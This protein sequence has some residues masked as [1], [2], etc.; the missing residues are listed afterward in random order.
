MKNKKLN[1][2]IDV[3]SKKDLVSKYSDD[4]LSLEL[5]EYLL[6]ELVGEDINSKVNINFNL[7]IKLTNKEQDEFKKI[8][9]QEF[10]ETLKE[11]DNESKSS[12]IQKMALTVAGI[13]F[14]LLSTFVST[15]SDVTQEI[16]DIFGWVALWE[17]AYAMFFTDG[18]R[19]KKIKR[20]KQIL[21]SEII[22]K[23]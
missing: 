17:V 18:K 23:D 16:L 21:N 14:I 15:L 12:N 9:R 5:K 10:K 11:L 3:H 4:T 13:T 2:D 19:R 1:I 6:N 22:F 7:Q 8:L 20:I